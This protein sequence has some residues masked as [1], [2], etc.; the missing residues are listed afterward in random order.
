MHCE[1]VFLFLHLEHKESER[2]VS[3]RTLAL[4]HGSHA[5]RRPLRRLRIP[6]AGEGLAALELAEFSDSYVLWL[7]RL[8][9]E[10]GIGW[11]GSCILGV[12]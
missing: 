8:R 2:E 4:R 1:A 3:H 5:G 6:G 10:A 9:V 11:N 7:P 12:S